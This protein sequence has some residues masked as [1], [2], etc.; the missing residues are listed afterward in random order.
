MRESPVDKFPNRIELKLELIRTTNGI[1]TND[2]RVP[3]ISLPYGADH[4]LN[5][6]TLFVECWQV[7][8]NLWTTWLLNK[9]LL[10]LFS[11]HLFQYDKNSVL[12]MHESSLIYLATEKTAIKTFMRNLE[13]TCVFCAIE[14]QN[15]VLFAYSAVNVIVWAICMT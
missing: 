3:L 10:I 13:R 2:K 5:S 6:R 4:Q 1:N 11:R 14:I 8:I 7:L 15:S 12:V 9:S